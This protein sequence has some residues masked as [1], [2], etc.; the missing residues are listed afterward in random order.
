MGSCLW[1]GVRPPE[2]QPVISRSLTWGRY[3]GGRRP[4]SDDSLHSPTVIPPS[5]LDKPSITKRYH[6]RRTRCHA[7]PRRSPTMVT[8]HDTRFDER[9]WWNDDC[10]DCGHLTVVG[11]HDTGPRV[12]TTGRRSALRLAV[13][14]RRRGVCVV[15][16]MFHGRG[17]WCFPTRACNCLH[18]IYSR[19]TYPA[20]ASLRVMVGDGGGMVGDGGGWWVVGVWWG[21]GGGGGDGG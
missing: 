4:S 15:P 20:S 8:L 21:M 1:A 7:S 6:R 17:G 2:S 10:E 14:S 13:F 19:P 12:G 18:I 3:H 9:R 16:L 11:L 5:A